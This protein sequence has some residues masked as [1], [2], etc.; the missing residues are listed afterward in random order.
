M[1]C[2]KKEKDYK[3]KKKRKKSECYCIGTCGFRVNRTSWWKQWTFRLH[4]TFEADWAVSS[5][6]GTPNT[7]KSNDLG[8][9][10]HRQSRNPN[11]CAGLCNFCCCCWSKMYSISTGWLIIIA[12]WL[13]SFWPWL[14]IGW[15]FPTNHKN[16]NALS[17]FSRLR[18]T[19]W[20][21]WSDHF[22]PAKLIKGILCSESGPLFSLSRNASPTTNL[23]TTPVACCPLIAC[24]INPWPQDILHTLVQSRRTEI[25]MDTLWK[26]T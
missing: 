19:R 23:F 24:L 10:K 17:L 6:K 15:S 5:V 9:L 16:V 26:S 21:C 8:N 12:K 14:K 3:I 4:S 20:R 13:V 25:V 11:L 2:L 7:F 18:P 1:C 22:R